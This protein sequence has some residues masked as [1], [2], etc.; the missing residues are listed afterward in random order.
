MISKDSLKKRTQPY[1]GARCCLNNREFTIT[2]LEYYP[3]VTEGKI[4]TSKSNV[5]FEKG[6]V[7]IKNASTINRAQ[8][9]IV[10]QR[11]DSSKNESIENILIRNIEI[12]NRMIE[13]PG[14]VFRYI[15]AN[16]TIAEIN[17]LEGNH[18][19]LI[20]MEAPKPNLDIEYGKRI[21]NGIPMVDVEEPNYRLWYK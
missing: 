19:S 6:D 16:T 4:S 3:Q 15:F 11:K 18:G 7:F 2:C 9:N 12:D 10:L 21:K 8:V 17:E 5:T 1:L 14:K 13:G 20:I